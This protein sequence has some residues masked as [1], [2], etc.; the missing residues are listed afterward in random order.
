M[1]YMRFEGFLVPRQWRLTLDQGL[2]VSWS[3]S[4][5]VTRWC[6]WCLCVWCLGTAT[7]SWWCGVV[8]VSRFHCA[9]VSRSCL[10]RALIFF[11]FVLVLCLW[12]VRS[13]GGAEAI[14]CRQRSHETSHKTKD[15]VHIH[16]AAFQRCGHVGL[17]PLQ[18]QC[19]RNSKT[20]RPHQHVYETW[21]ETSRI[22]YATLSHH[23]RYVLARPHIWHGNVRCVSLCFSVASARPHTRSLWCFDCAGHTTNP[24]RGCWMLRMCSV[25]AS[26]A[27]RSGGCSRVLVGTN[28]FRSETLEVLVRDA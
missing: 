24:F 6:R 13:L 21:I 3:P 8:L 11:V 7:V 27:D 25:I 26:V 5:R 17:L 10:V 22:F 1:S 18:L 16:I 28:G 23:V 19:C 14:S 9:L 12:N 4:L 20:R 15:F 2:R